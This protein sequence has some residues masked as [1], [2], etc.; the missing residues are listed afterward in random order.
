MTKKKRIPARWADYLD[1]FMRGFQ[2]SWIAERFGV[3]VETVEHAI[4]Q[5]LKGQK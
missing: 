3:H 1:W 5:I 4:R 2:M